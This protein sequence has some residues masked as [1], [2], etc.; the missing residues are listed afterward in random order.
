ML[1]FRILASGFI[2]FILSH[3]VYASNLIVTL[4][5]QLPKVV[6]NNVRSHLGKL[7]DSDLARSVFIYSA[8][9]NTY[10]ALQAL[11]YYQAEII[12]SVNNDPDNTEKT[13][14][15]PWQLNL[16]IRLNSPTLIDKVVIT[17]VGEASQDP[18]FQALLNNHE[19]KQGERLHHGKYEDLKSD[20][21]SLALQRGYF[22][23]EL[24]ENKIAIKKQYHYADITLRYKSGPRYQ[25][26]EV[27]FNDVELEPELLSRLIPFQQNEY[28][29]TTT[30]HQLQHQLQSTQYFGSIIAVPG[31]KV[32]DKINHKYTIP[33][34]VSL[35]PAKSHQFDLGVGY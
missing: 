27:T 7:P 35:T 24:T 21:L 31:D 1:Y 12:A 5:G 6:H 23:G 2:I 10:Q 20:L 28:Y 15:N 29:S 3:S 22:N 13:N 9:N 33:I 25:F 4:N 30:F 14:Q 34:N 19:I 11:G 26:G 8:K 32:E 17:V 16:N 18:A